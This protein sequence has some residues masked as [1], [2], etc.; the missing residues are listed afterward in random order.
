MELWKRINDAVF[1]RWSLHVVEAK[2]DVASL[3]LIEIR[4]F[5]ISSQSLDFMLTCTQEG[6][7]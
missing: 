3:R 5:I 1:L 4:H 6:C 2:T 7:V